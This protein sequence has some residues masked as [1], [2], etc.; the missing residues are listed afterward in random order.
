[1]DVVW[2]DLNIMLERRIEFANRR[3]VALSKLPYLRKSCKLPLGGAK[4][5]GVRE[6]STHA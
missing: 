1:M 3:I 5:P 2:R 4:F 6:I